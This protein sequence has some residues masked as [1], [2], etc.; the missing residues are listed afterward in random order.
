MVFFMISDYG[1]L[2]FITELI[3]PIPLNSLNSSLYI[4]VSYLFASAF[5]A[6][7]QQN[8]AFSCVKPISTFYFFTVSHRESIAYLVD[9]FRHFSHN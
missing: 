7:Y 1:D 2:F 4:K 8:L 9:S 3:A 6:S 5:L